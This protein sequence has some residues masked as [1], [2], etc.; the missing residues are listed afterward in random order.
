MFPDAVSERAQRHVRELTALARAGASAALVFV[1]LRDDCTAWAPCHEVR[2]GGGCGS[3]PAD[4]AAHPPLHAPC[5]RD[6]SRR[7]RS[8]CLAGTG[9]WF[10][11][12]LC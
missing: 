4:H 8:C 6:A 3:M 2:W 5:C 9:R 11:G 12:V 1:V 10:G 7:L